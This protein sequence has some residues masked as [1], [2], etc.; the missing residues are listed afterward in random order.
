[1]KLFRI[2]NSYLPLKGFRCLT[3]LCLLLVRNDLETPINEQELRHECI[4]AMQQ[5]ELLV[6]ALL[7]ALIVIPLA[8]IGWAWLAVVPLV[9]FLLYG[10]CWLLELLL[11]PRGQAYR[12]I[13][14]ETEA[15]YNEADPDYLRNRKPFAWVRYISNAKYPYFPRRERGNKR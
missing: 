6:V 14:F 7:L 15:I 3:A 4:H 1:M 11:S 5:F 10:F 2:D 13:C 9:P 12:N 8:G